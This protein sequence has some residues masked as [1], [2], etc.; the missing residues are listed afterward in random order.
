[1]ADDTV[2]FDGFEEP[3]ANFTRIPNAFL[4]AMSIIDTVGEMKV[5]YY[6]LRHTW[7]FRDDCKKITLDEFQYGRKY[8]DGTRLDDGTGLTK[9]TIIDGLARAE[10]HGF[11]EVEVDGRDAARIRKSYSL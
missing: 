6:I 1:M 7:G 11:I 8:K 3:T 5:V 9:P 10:E 4:E 2:T